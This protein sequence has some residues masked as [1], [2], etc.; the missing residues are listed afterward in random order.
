MFTERQLEMVMTWRSNGAQIQ[1]FRREGRLE[2]FAFR[3][4][5]EVLL[6]IVEE[7]QA[8]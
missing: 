1:M 5:L 2:V 7:E 6:F 3:D 4:N 8:A